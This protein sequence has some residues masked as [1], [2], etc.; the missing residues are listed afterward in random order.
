MSKNKTQKNNVPEAAA[1]GSCKTT[2]CECS[3]GGAEDCCGSGA[4]KCCCPFIINEYTLAFWVLRLWLGFRA[5]F[6]GLSKFKKT[7]LDGGVRASSEVTNIF[8]ENYGSVLADSAVPLANASD[9]AGQA[10]AKATQAVASGLAPENASEIY[11]KAYNAALGKVQGVSDLANETAAA[12]ANA[13]RKAFET[14]AKEVIEMKIV[15]KGL[16]EGGA[17]TFESFKQADIWYMPEWALKIFDNALGYV[18]LVLGLTLLLGI[19]TRISLFVQGLLYI[20]LTLGF[21]AIT[22]EPGSSMGITMLGVH[23]ALVVAALAL[24]KHNKLTL[25]K[26]F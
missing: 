25:L 17:W 21:I 5:V 9:I 14:N 4:K 20:G 26:Q 22:Q 16:P 8:R 10:A 12:A 13:A 3:N 2:N 7:E 19:G 6:T 24:S 23:V 11:N 15:H 1:E 18:L